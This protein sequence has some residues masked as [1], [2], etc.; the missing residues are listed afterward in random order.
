MPHTV[1]RTGVLLVLDK[2][3]KTLR[4]Y[5]LNLRTEIAC[6][7]PFTIAFNYYAPS[8]SKLVRTAFENIKLQHRV[9]PLK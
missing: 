7:I 3:L 1:Q 4:T 5:G 2:T 8:I 6:L 9:V